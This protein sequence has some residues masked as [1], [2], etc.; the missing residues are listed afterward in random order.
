MER[1]EDGADRSLLLD[2]TLTADMKYFLDSEFHDTGRTIEP[3]SLALVCEDGRELVLYNLDFDW[4]TA[5]DWLRI[6]VRPH[7]PP[8]TV[9]GW[10]RRLNFASQILKFIGD[11][12]KPEFWAYYADY[13]WVLFCQLWG[14]ML[15]LP[16]HFPKYCLDL[17]QL[18]RHRGNL[19][20]HKQGTDEHCALADARWVRDQ[21]FW[22]SKLKSIDAIW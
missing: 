22:L 18:T 10:W 15:D 3:I 20:L 9:D 1:H 19:K 14:R 4:A 11:D 16:K 8:E 7:L 13:D 5:D 21:Y 2:T 6:N 12:P 17:K